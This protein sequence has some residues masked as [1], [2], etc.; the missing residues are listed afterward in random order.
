MRAF[1]FPFTNAQQ[2]MLITA[3]EL[4]HLD[5]VT[6]YIEDR[7]LSVRLSRDMLKKSGQSNGINKRPF[8]AKFTNGSKIIGRIPQKD[9]KGVKGMHPRKLEIDEGQ[10]YPEPG[11]VELMETLRYGDVNSTWRIHGVSRGVRDR[12]YKLCQPESGYYVHKVTAMHRPDWTPEE[13]KAK[14]EYYGSRNHPDY[15]RNILGL[16][17]DALSPLFVLAHL[18]QCVAGETSDFTQD[19]Y[20]SVSISD[21]RL[22]DSGMPITELIQLPPRH[23]AGKYSKFWAGADIGMTNH[24]TEILIFGEEHLTKGSGVVD[25]P[26]VRL[27]MIARINLQRIS[28]LDQRT[29]FRHLY[30]FYQPMGAFGMDRTGLGLPIYQDIV[31]EGGGLDKVIRGYNFSEKIVVGWDKGG[32]PDEPEWEFEKYDPEENAIMANVLEHSTD[33]LRI[34][35]DQRKILLPWDTDVIKEFQGQTYTVVKSNT[36]PYGKKEFNKGT[37]HALD[38]A[39]MAILGYT[40]SFIEP[41][42]NRDD[43]SEA[44]ELRWLDENDFGPPGFDLF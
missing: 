13:R 7:L 20:Y 28:A 15:R 3:P 11:W 6:K 24:P 1:A 21:E 27:A 40:Q 41:L 8:E 4:I 44:I 18:M 16:H 36:N 14:A 29:V 19:M 17:G 39:R 2:E 12:Y 33:Q 35:V 9:G 30:D 42:L 5:P 38:A 31:A 34:L 25:G 22:R 23:L 37:F 26:S 10:D 43:N 32:R